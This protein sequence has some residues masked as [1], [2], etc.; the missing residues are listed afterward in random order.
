MV[1]Y[2]SE[3]MNYSSLSID[4]T[5]QISKIEKKNDGIYFTPPTTIMRNIDALKKYMKNV[6]K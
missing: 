6:K 3:P 1:I 2:S 4:L 5:K